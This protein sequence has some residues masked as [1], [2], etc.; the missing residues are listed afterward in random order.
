MERDRRV[1][2][3]TS[4][5]RIHNKDLGHSLTQILYTKDA[6]ESYGMLMVAEEPALTRYLADFASRFCEHQQHSFFEGATRAYMI[7]RGL[8]GMGYDFPP[9]SKETVE[10]CRNSETRRDRLLQYALLVNFPQVVGKS[11]DNFTPD[12][13]EMIDQYMIR[14]VNGLE[15]E[16][17]FPL[18][19]VYGVDAFKEWLDLHDMAF[20]GGVHEVFRLKKK[21]VELWEPFIVPQTSYIN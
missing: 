13:Y 19:E 6:W 21:Q 16:D 1:E 3:A 10:A 7:L 17:L 18:D 9:V 12:E 11:G 8:G 5:P 15:T 14:A 2:L 20:R 4:F